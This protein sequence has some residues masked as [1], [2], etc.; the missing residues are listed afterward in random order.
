MAAFYPTIVSDCMV[1]TINFYEDHFDFV[2]AIEN[3]GYVLMRHQ[4]NPSA[5]I[6]IFDAAHKC[7]CDVEQSVKGVIVNIV[8]QDVKGKYDALYMEGLDIHKEYGQDINGKDHF[9]VFDP[10]RIMVNVHAPF[11]LA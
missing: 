7:V 5:C 8:I 3:D 6:A 2:P 10:N 4:E 9:V 1:R 11:S